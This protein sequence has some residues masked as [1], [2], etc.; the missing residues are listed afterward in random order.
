MLSFSRR[1]FSFFL[2]SLGGPLLNFGGIFEGRGP[3]MCIG[4][5]PGERSKDLE[6]G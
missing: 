2:L 4:G 6:D 3:E 5:S 1:K